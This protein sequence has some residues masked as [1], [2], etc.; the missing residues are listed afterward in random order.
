MGLEYII[1]ACLVIVIILLLKRSEPSID[2]SDELTRARHEQNQILSN[3]IN[4]MENK[5]NQSHELSSRTNT[6]NQELL[7]KQV[8]YSNQEIVNLLAKM[9]LNLTN[10]VKSN[11]QTNKEIG[12]N[13]ALLKVIND[14]MNRLEEEVTGLSKILDNKQLRGAFGE[15]RL[16]QILEQNYGVGSKL[17]EEQYLLNN[18]KRCDV[19]LKYPEQF[20]SIAIDAKFPLE[21][22]QNIIAAN[23]DDK[24]K[25]ERL[26]IQDIKKHIKD[27]SEKYIVNGQ[28]A[29]SAMMFIPSEAVYYYVLKLDESI[30][31]FAYKNNVWI[32]SP[33]TIMAIITS[34]DVALKDLELNANL[35]KVRSEMSGLA[36]EFVRFEKRFNDYNRRFEQ[37]ETERNNLNITA[38]KIITKFNT[39]NNK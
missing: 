16:S 32:T 24:S 39:L 9:Q 20:K 27:I 17:Y 14:Q 12:E 35:Q 8:S 23:A 34:L 18:G 3:A 30:I 15:R 29:P 13:I 33:T 28:T 37:L 19:F 36:D 22:Y 26:F 11:S 4:M 1:I 31:D 2:V 38:Q 21:N 6:T 5:I 10:E 25:Y 7:N